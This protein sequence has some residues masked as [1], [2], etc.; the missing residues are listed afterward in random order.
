MSIEL[1]DEQYLE[2]LLQARE[3]QGGR[4]RRFS[5][6]GCVVWLAC[7][8]IFFGTLAVMLPQ[9][10]A[11]YPVPV[12]STMFVTPQIVVGTPLPVMRQQQPSGDAQ[13][14]ALPPSDQGAA[15]WPTLTPEPPT[16]EPTQAPVP[17][18]FWTEEERAAWTATA[19][20]WHDPQTLPTAPPDFAKYVDERCRDPEQVAES[21]TLQLFC[22]GAK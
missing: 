17:T 8:V 6:G 9:I 4:R 10:A 1:T 15:P 14:A 13:P 2:L 18:S 19:E 7:G 5:L 12:L 20:A 16:P 21:A 3:K 11:I 22:G